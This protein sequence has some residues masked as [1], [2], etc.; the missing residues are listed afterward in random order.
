V[1]VQRS[2]DD[3]AGKTL[4]GMAEPF[5]SSRR[6][7]HGERMELLSELGRGRSLLSLASG[8]SALAFLAPPFGIILGASLGGI[9]AFT[10]WRAHTR[11]GQSADFRVWAGEQI[12][13]AQLSIRNGFA[14][15]I[16]DLQNEI[17]SLVRR[18]LAEREQS[19]QNSIAEARAMQRTEH[20]TF[21]AMRR[22]LEH[23]IARA[24]RLRLDCAAALQ[25][26]GV[27][28]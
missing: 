21:A 27:Q 6:L 25:A 22:S 28:G 15:Q 8:S 17:R 3:I 4:S 18:V 5:T 2:I 14:L 10:S 1:S 19:L 23:R 12:A 9:F 20:E 16:V 26:S 13:N 24:R 7:A 11:S